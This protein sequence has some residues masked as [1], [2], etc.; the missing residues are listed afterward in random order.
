MTLLESVDMREDSGRLETNKDA[1]EKRYAWKDRVHQ[2]PNTH[3]AF[4]ESSNPCIWEMGEEGSGIQG[5]P[6]L[7]RILSQDSKKKKKKKK[8]THHHKEWIYILWSTA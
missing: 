7:Q 1:E 8:Q 4:L 5:Q 3:P 6:G 2:P